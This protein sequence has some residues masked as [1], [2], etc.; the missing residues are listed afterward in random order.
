MATARGRTS[1]TRRWRTTLTT[2]GVRSIGSAPHP[3]SSAGAW[4]GWPHAGRPRAAART[5]AWGSPRARRRRNGILACCCAPGSSGPRR[6]AS[7]IDDPDHQ[8]AMMPDLDR[9]ERLVA[10]S[11]LGPESLLAR[12]DRRAGIVLGPLPCPLLIVLG[13]R[14]AQWPRNRYADLPLAAAGPPVGA[15]HRGLVL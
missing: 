15:S 11:S 10:L 5:R 4:A 3:C 12:D 7:S 13:A 8:D 6:T 9:D 14:D 1:P 2:S